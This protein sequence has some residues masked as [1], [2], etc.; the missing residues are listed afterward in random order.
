MKKIISVVMVVAAFIAVFTFLTGIVSIQDIW[1]SISGSS[2][3]TLSIPSEA[4]TDTQAQPEIAQTP[5][6]DSPSTSLESNFS[7]MRDILLGTWSGEY[8]AGQGKTSLNLII[9]DY[10]DGNITAYFYF[11]P[12]PEN[13]DMVLR[14]L[15][16]MR[17]TISDDMTI[18]L[19]GYEWVVRPGSFGFLDIYGMLDIDALVI[20]SAEASLSVHKISNDVAVPQNVNV[21]STEGYLTSLI[22]FRMDGV[23]GFMINNDFNTL[24]GSGFPEDF[25]AV[26]GGNPYH[27]VI[28]VCNFG[29]FELIYNLRGAYS[30]IRGRVG[31]DD[32]T[33]TSNDGFMGVGASRF[34]G[35]ATVI[36]L[37]HDDV[38][39]EVNI[40]TTGFP[41]H[42][43][44]SIQGVEHFVI[45]FD[46]P[47]NPGW[48]A[49]NFNKFF[50]LIDVEIE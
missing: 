18:S 14:G 1:S 23:N 39:H 16:S 25:F 29:P 40:S 19:I 13:P 2:E 7:S 38:L 45:R 28:S 12:H 27:Q 9:T 43:E 11:S 48:F 37:S 4:D 10:M 20:S 47:H 34:Q 15:Y 46:F 35:D 5:S 31:F 26:S 36:F 22:P 3:P 17:G 32:R 30:T 6:N 33:P 49:D 41:Q 8:T 24:R 42:F 21:I 50:N 44:F